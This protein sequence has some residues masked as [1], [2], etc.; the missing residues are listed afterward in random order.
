MPASGFGPDKQVFDTATMSSG[1]AMRPRPRSPLS[2]IS[3]SIG[4]I[5]W[6]RRLEARNIPLGG[7]MRPH[8]RVH[9]GRDQHGRSV[10]SSTVDARSSANRSPSW[11]S[12]PR[13]QGQR[14]RD[15]I[16]APAG[17]GDILLVFPREEFGI[18]MEGGESADGERRDEFL[19]A[20]GHDRTHAR[21]AFRS[22]RIRSGSCMRQCHPRSQA[23]CAFRPRS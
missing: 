19:R 10:A 5:I 18:D 16:R 11:P 22:L 15:R 6:I 8:L 7:R 20:A 23:K 12:G 13:S 9:G 2:A 1:S 17:Y 3:P 4:P 21:T 14:A